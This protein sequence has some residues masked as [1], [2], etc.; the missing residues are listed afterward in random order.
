MVLAI[1]EMKLNTNM[2][3]GNLQHTYFSACRFN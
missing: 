2:E 3:Q 1:N